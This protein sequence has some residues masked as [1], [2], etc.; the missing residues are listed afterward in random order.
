[1]DKDG[2]DVDLYVTVLDGRFPV[3]DDY[4]FSST[5]LGP[6]SIVVNSNDYFF[7]SSGYNK[8]NGVLFMV[9]VKALTK[10]V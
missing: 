9:G 6:D 1:V 3:S 10:N 7:N 2:D 8:S 4:D 5:N